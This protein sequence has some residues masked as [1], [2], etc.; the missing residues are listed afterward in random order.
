M[1]SKSD[2]RVR[3]PWNDQ[4]PTWKMC[5][6]QSTCEQFIVVII[7]DKRIHPYIHIQSEN[8]QYIGGDMCVWMLRSL[9]AASLNKFANTGV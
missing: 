1:E 4:N 5:A 8:M 7:L 3:D 2:Q 9:G 6:S